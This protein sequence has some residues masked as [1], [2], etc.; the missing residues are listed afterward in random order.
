MSKFEI[1]AEQLN[2]AAAGRASRAARKLPGVTSIRA[3]RSRTFTEQYL[4]EVEADNRKTAEKVRSLVW[5]EN[6]G[7]YAEL[8]KAS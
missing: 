5:E 6:G 8:R 4:F 1:E 2:A 3:T 7:A